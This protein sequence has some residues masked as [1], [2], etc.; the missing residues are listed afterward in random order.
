MAY[1]CGAV[2]S[3]NLGNPRYRGD[4][5]SGIWYVLVRTIGAVGG[6]PIE[7]M[8]RLTTQSIIGY[9]VGTIGFIIGAT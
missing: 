7:S 2:G 9:I 3:K 5:S 4:L 1:A 6:A 8:I